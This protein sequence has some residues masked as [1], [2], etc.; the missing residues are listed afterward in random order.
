[1]APSISC[2]A[3]ADGGAVRRVAFNPDGEHL[4]TASDDKTARVQ[5]WQSDEGLTDEA[6]RRLTRNLKK[7]EWKP[8]AG[9]ELYPKTCPNLPVPEE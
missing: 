9:D 5:R 3:T 6:C 7:E 1:M 4:A 8:H 2:S